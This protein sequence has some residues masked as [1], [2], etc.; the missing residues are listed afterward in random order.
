MRYG[1]IICIFI[2]SLLTFGQNRSNNFKKEFSEFYPN[3]KI[4]VTGEKIGELVVDTLF[5]FFKNGEL[6]TIQIF[7]GSKYPRNV[8]YYENLKGMYAKKRIGNFLQINDST[9]LREGIWK[10]YYK[11]G[12]IMDSCVFKNDSEIYRVRYNKKGQII[13]DQ[14]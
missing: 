1:I 5:T 14:K 7:Y 4:K 13:I 9:Y 12:E 3:G 8:Y 10:Y 2:F 11:T 6:Q